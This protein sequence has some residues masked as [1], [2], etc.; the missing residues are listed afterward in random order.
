M[1]RNEVARN[2]RNR[3]TRNGGV[4]AQQCYLLNIRRR[5]RLKAPYR[6][7]FALHYLI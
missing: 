6:Q 3:G 7:R 2:E 1:R 4:A 5:S